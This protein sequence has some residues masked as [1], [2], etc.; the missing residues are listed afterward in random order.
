MFCE[1]CGSILE[2]DAKFCADCGTDCAVEQSS[3][4]VKTADSTVVSFSTTCN[5]LVS[6]GVITLPFESLKAMIFDSF[7][8][9]YRGV[10][11][12]VRVMDGSV[13]VG[14]KI[15]KGDKIADVYT[16]G[17]NT[18]TAIKTILDSYVITKELVE[19]RNIVLKV[20]GE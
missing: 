9:S 2:Q 1:K 8:D 12:I 6:S 5:N 18:E 16:N 20:I 10:V 19:P 14:D 17:K 11:I 15:T 13:K 7:Y 3:Q 4:T